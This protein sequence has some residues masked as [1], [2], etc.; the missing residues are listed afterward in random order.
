MFPQRKP[1]T[2]PEITIY[3]NGKLGVSEN[4]IR[5]PGKIWSVRFR[6]KSSSTDAIGNNT[7]G[8]CTLTADPRHQRAT[9][10][11]AHDIPPVFTFY[12]GALRCPRPVSCLFVCAASVG[13]HGSSGRKR[14][15][16]TILIVTRESQVFGYAVIQQG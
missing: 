10:F 7:F 6:T 12:R 2:M 8:S 15:E 1:P 16:E 5:L 4:D 11:G 14:I 3:K 13:G 9:R